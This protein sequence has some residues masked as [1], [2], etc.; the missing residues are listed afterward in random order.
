MKKKILSILVIIVLFTTILGNV[1]AATNAVK[2]N[3]ESTE[4][5]KDM[6]SISVSSMPTIFLG[7]CSVRYTGNCATNKTKVD[8]NYPMEDGIIFILV[9]GE[10]TDTTA[11]IVN[12]SIFCLGCDMAEVSFTL[13]GKTYSANKNGNGRWQYWPLSV[14]PGLTLDFELS[15]QFKDNDNDCGYAEKKSG[16]FHFVYDP[17]H[18][19][20]S[21]DII[22]FGKVSAGNTGNKKVTL[23]NDGGAT[24]TVRLLIEGEDKEYFSF[25]GDKRFTLEPTRDK[26]IDLYFTP[27][28][29]RSY[30]AILN[31]DG[32]SPCNDI[33]AQ[34][35]GTTKKNIVN[36]RIGN[37]IIWK[38]LVKFI[39]TNEYPL[40]RLLNHLTQERAKIL[41]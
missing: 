4:Y 39:L 16:T 8:I 34:I 3:D 41:P 14:R 17:P 22:N 9:P 19:S 11:V 31:V 10:Y 21:P 18:I 6:L 20:L 40:L 32:D 30:S 7:E 23:V 1:F 2:K 33:S 36:I 24:A 27:D 15:A 5:L 12:W 38:N 28:E 26:T 29:N 37:I 35:L 25:K 13:K